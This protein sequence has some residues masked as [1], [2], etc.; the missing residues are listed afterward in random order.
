VHLINCKRVLDK[1]IERLDALVFRELMATK[2]SKRIKHISICEGVVSSLW[3]TWCHFCRSV[4]VHSTLGAFTSSGRV[5]CSNYAH[6][7]ERQIITLAI[8]LSRSERIPSYIP[9]ANGWVD[10][11]WGDTEKLNKIITGID[12]SN[13][14]I[15]LSA[16]GSVKHLQSLQ[17]SRNACSHISKYTIE[18]LKDM[19]VFYNNNSLMHPVDVMFWTVPETGRFLWKSWLD[20]MDLISSIIIE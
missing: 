14:E 9:M 10:L 13:K 15:L 12:M 3:Q 2:K 18:Q 19:R 20:E 1:R 8:K 5:V 16:F 11:A 6:L 17:K 7:D 4:V